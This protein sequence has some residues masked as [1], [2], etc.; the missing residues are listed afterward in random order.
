MEL[1]AY[2]DFP[3]F[4]CSFFRLLRKDYHIANPYQVESKFVTLHA[5]LKSTTLHS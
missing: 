2:M 4:A 1:F 3:T 5:Q